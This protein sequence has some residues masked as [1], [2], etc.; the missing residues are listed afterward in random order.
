MQASPSDLATTAE[1]GS[2]ERVSC[3]S[4]REGVAGTRPAHALHA[5]APP[6]GKRGSRGPTRREEGQVGGR[7]PRKMHLLGEGR[8]ALPTLW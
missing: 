3:S 4:D 8:P 7:A 6:E 1:L 5:G 2:Q